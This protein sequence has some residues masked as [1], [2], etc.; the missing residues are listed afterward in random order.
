M[1]YIVRQK[2]F[3]LADQFSIKDEFENVRF[4]VKGEFFTMGKKLHLEDNNGNALF[5]IK[6]KLFNF[7]PVYEIYQGEMI[8]ATLRKK[9]S[10][11]KP[12]IEI[13]QNGTPYL[14]SGDAF[15]HEFTI[16]RNDIAVA[17]ISKKW[18]AFS[19]TY[20]IEITGNENDAFILAM[21][22]CIDE[23]IYHGRN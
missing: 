9:L 6:Q 13:D 21:A 2:V 18:F 3:S 20:G 23:I 7:L 17:A 15:S 8:F 11:L 12:K 14:I 4:V 22:I 16:F 5:F 19:D 1:K 10:F